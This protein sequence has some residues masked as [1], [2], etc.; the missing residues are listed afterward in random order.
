MLTSSLRILKRN[1]TSDLA[2]SQSFPTQQRSGKVIRWHN[3]P[4]ADIRALAKH[5]N[6][7]VDVSEEGEIVSGFLNFVIDARHV[8]QLG[9]ELVADNVTAISE[10]I[11]NAYDADATE[12]TVVFSEMARHVPGGTLTIRD[13]G[14]GM[15]L[16]DITQRWMTISTNYKD[17]NNTSDLYRRKRAGQKGIGRFATESLGSSLQLRSTKKGSPDRIV[18]DF[19]WADSYVSGQLLESVQNPYRIERA[20]VEEHGTELTVRKLLDPWNE[21]SVQRVNDAV[22]LLQ[23]PFRVASVYASDKSEQSNDPGFRVYLRYERDTIHIQTNVELDTVLFAATAWI[24][25]QVR[26]DGSLRR[27]ISSNL[28]GMDEEEEVQEAS[29]LT[30]PI[31]FKAAYFIFKRDAMDPVAN[32]TV[33][34]ARQLTNLYGGIRLYRDSMRILPYG[35]PDN[36]WLSLDAIYRRRGQVLA[37]I[38][39]SNFVGEVEIS[40]EENVLLIDTASREGVLENE[41]FAELQVILRDALVW[42]VNRVAAVRQKKISAGSNSEPEPTPRESL[43][44]E[45]ATTAQAVVDA[46]EETQRS[47]ALRELIRVVQS[48]VVEARRSDRRQDQEKLA[49]LDELSLLRVLASVGSAIAVFSHEVRAVLTQAIAAMGDVAQ[50]EIERSSRETG[51]I[52]LAERGLI[53]VSDLA[54]HLDIYISHSG[55]RERSE[56]SLSDVLSE[57]K[58]SVAPLLERRGIAIEISVSPAH[59]RTRPMSRSELIAMLYNLLTN[60][61][62]ALDSE[63]MNERRIRIEVALRGKAIVI[64]FLDNGMGIAE[65]VRER[66]FDAFVTT[67][68]ESDSELGS[69]TGLGLKIV[70]D[71]AESNGGSA[72]IGI[73][74]SPYV[75]CIEIALPTALGESNF[76]N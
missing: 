18:I 70:A 44:D 62:K 40:R 26:D 16:A 25:V 28:L 33:K 38:G 73:A 1:E 52:E 34:R 11:K 30:G 50:D 21:R 63:G 24:E 4:W 22:H 58:T 56:L 43:L 59:L 72:T 9:R 39:N 55:R 10:L 15:D 20:P 68:N 64:R 36:D 45:I 19:D 65:L 32:V 6:R 61:V 76:P 57:F 14:C 27:R 51:A 75:T 49:L 5:S 67:T 8:R 66:I 2:W 3:N 69:G 17:Q 13:D 29:L 47:A 53:G 23:P 41:A 37:P 60:A 54:M 42:G 74:S 31:E 71:L 12:V 48:S 46:S 7:N 35:E